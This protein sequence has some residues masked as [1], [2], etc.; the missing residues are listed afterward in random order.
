MGTTYEIKLVVADQ[1][2]SAFDSAIFLEAGSFN[3]GGDLGPDQTIANGNPGCLGT[4]IT[5]DAQL[6]NTGLTFTWYKDGVI[7]PGAYYST[8]DVTTD[9]TYKFTAMV[10]VQPQTRWLSNLLF[11]QSLINLQKIF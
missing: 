8:L 2:D 4:P 9:G 7:I 1:G 5:L 11:P 10:G 3:I 6:N